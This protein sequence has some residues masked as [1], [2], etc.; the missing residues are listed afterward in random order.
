MKR[1]IAII[2]ALGL[3]ITLT[4]TSSQAASSAKDIA[5]AKKYQM[6]LN[7]LLVY[8]AVTASV[9]K[10]PKISVKIDKY[11][12]P[13][14]TNNWPADLLTV[15]THGI[16][17]WQDQYHP[18]AA[19]PT[20]FFTE[21]DRDWLKSTLTSVGIP[22]DNTLADFDRNVNLNG[23][24][25][26]WGGS[27][28]ENGRVFNLYLNG[29]S[30]PAWMNFPASQVSAHEWTHN[31]QAAIAGSTEVLPCWYKEGSATY[32]GTTLAAK[33]ESDYSATR[34]ATLIWQSNAFSANPPNFLLYNEKAIPGGYESYFDSRDTT[35]PANQ[36]GPD[37]AYSLGYLATEYLMEL[38]G[39]AAQI[40]FMKLAG[41]SPWRD[42]LASVYGKKWPILRKEIALYIRQSAKLI[43]APSVPANAASTSQTPTPQPVTA[44]PS[45]SASPSQSQSPS[46]S[47]PTAEAD[48]APPGA[49]AIGRSCLDAGVEGFSWKQEKIK[50]G[51]NNGKLQWLAA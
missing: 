6:P 24:A 31:A 23:P 10:A 12:A 5:L 42:A 25:T 19:V 41:T 34:A 15:L 1:S 35:Y 32:F 2:T 27:S 38:K 7:A 16:T 49:A 3:L 26:T 39:K 48:G 11:V 21:K 18:S 37:G 47:T 46:V 30:T 13:T 44:S 50:C 51:L 29:T 36:C 28:N 43:K 8:R 45:A 9:T 20:F 33:S 17:Y 40:S 22:A 4:P 14:I